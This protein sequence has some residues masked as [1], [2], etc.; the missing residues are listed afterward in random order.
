MQSVANPALE[1]QGTVELDDVLWKKAVNLSAAI[2]HYK[3]TDPESQG[4]IS[5][6]MAIALNRA[7]LSHEEAGVWR[8]TGGTKPYH[9][10]EKRCD[11]ED[12]VFKRAPNG[13]CKHR[14][15]IW[16]ARKAAKFAP[17]DLDKTLEELVAEDE[18]QVDKPPP[19]PVQTSGAQDEDTTALLTN[20]GTVHV[21]RSQ[22][23]YIKDHAQPF[24]KY[25]GLL[26]LAHERGLLS[27]DADW[28]LNEEKLSLARATAVFRDGRVFKEC[29][30]S[31]PSNAPRVGEA[32]RRMSL[33]RSKARCLRDALGINAV[34]VE[35]ME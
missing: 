11:C 21:P 9:V 2:A 14:L 18:E 17:A 25:A 27:I 29:G 1:A 32:W 4:H 34:C 16:I 10:D 28:T 3:I 5:R 30:D 13:R 19:R 33:T 35:E 24:I 6:G 12:F 15:A 26:V 23:E 7:Q 20:T 8:V 31:T 22:V